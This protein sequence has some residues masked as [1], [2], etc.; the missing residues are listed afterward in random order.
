MALS[1]TTR[2]R[3]VRMM[4][5]TFTSTQAAFEETFRTGMIETEKPRHA[6]KSVRDCFNGYSR[7][8]PTTLTVIVLVV[9]R[10]DTVGYQSMLTALDRPFETARGGVISLPSCSRS[11]S[12]FGPCCRRASCGNRIQIRLLNACLVWCRLYW[13]HVLIKGGLFVKRR[14]RIESV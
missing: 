5:V 1:T 12:R 8:V 11:L 13:T 6:I 2:G 10:T 9:G 4:V 14:F 7:L 3:I